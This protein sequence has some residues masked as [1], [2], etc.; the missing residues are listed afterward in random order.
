MPLA[1]GI[2]ALL[3]FAL[4]VWIIRRGHKKSVK[5]FS[6]EGL[7]L[8]DGRTFRWTDLNRVV[9]K[10]RIRPYNR[11]TIWRTEIEFKNGSAWVIPTKVSNYGEV[12]E[13][14]RSLPCEHTEARA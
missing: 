1:I 2:M 13:L 14:I 9:D 7:V 5:Y 6:E 3:M 10:V 4:I 11:K 8:N 12:S